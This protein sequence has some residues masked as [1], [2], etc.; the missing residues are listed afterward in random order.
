MS[1][2]LMCEPWLR[3]IRANLDQ[4]KRKGH[5]ADPVVLSMEKL[6]GA[7]KEAR[8]SEKRVLDELSR[9]LKGGLVQK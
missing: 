9:R 7:L 4:A 3:Q 6:Y 8:E 1:D 5:G 2:N